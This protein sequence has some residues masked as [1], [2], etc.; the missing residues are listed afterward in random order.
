MSATNN[1]HFNKKCNSVT[2]QSGQELNTVYTPKGDFQVTLN[3]EYGS[4]L[5]RP[6]DMRTNLR[7]RGEDNLEK[8]LK[9][10]S[11]SLQCSEDPDGLVKIS[12]LNPEKLTKLDNIKMKASDIFKHDPTK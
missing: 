5:K 12:E 9:Q 7:E 3:N 4:E 11:A 2:M 6:Y 1:V 10:D 8:F